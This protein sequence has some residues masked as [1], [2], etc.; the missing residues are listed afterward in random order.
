MLLQEPVKSSQSHPSFSLPSWACHTKGKAS[1]LIHSD[2]PS[3]FL[4]NYSI[5]SDTHD[6]AASL[7]TPPDS[8][9]RVIFISVYRR[10]G[11]TPDTNASICSGFLHWV[12]ETLDSYVSY[13][14]ALVIGGDFNLHSTRLGSPTNG[15]GAKALHLIGDALAPDGA[16]LNDGSITRPGWTQSRPNSQQQLPSAIDITLATSI[17]SDV[18]FSGW[19][20]EDG[21][22]SD[23]DRI[24][25]KV[26]GQPLDTPQPAT[27]VRYTLAS[28]PPSTSY[29]DFKHQVSHLLNSNGW[30]HPSSPPHAAPHG[31]VHEDHESISHFSPVPLHTTDINTLNH[32]IT[33][34]LMS[35]AEKTGIINVI[36]NNTLRDK[37]PS[38]PSY[39]SKK[40]TKLLLLKRKCKKKIEGIKAAHSLPYSITIQYT[41]TK[42]N[43]SHNKKKKQLFIG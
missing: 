2:I 9:S 3:H 13:A 7:V 29:R 8:N 43:T 20:V 41:L 32:S 10:Y 21:Y 6:T 22:R 28:K 5:H 1:I 15:P 36:S 18:A 19:H 33:I 23:H 11:S 17:N 12:Q 34:S 30:T 39:W 42:L 40:C 27:E 4:P 14:D 25:F 26:T 35:A 24:L 38:P 16:I 31:M 37:P